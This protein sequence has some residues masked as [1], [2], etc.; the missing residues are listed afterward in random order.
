MTGGAEEPR[1]ALAALARRFMF[2]LAL[3]GVVLLVYLAIRFRAAHDQHALAW[4]G[5]AVIVIAFGIQSGRARPTLRIGIAL[6]CVGTVVATLGLEWT[7][8]AARRAGFLRNQRALE[9]LTGVPYDSRSIPQV[10]SDLWKTDSSVVPSIVP[11]IIAE[12]SQPATDPRSRFVADI[13]PLAGVSD[14]RTVQLCNEHGA[15]PLYHSDQHGFLNPPAAWAPAPG[16][17]VVIGDSF[18]HGYCV[19]ADSAF[20]NVLRQRWPATLNLGMG[21]NGPLAELATLTEYGIP[22]DPGVVLWVYFENDLPDL[23]RERQDPWL[24]RYLAPGFTQHLWQRQASVDSVLVPWIRRVYTGGMA[25]RFFAVYGL[26]EVLT[27]TAIRGLVKRAMAGKPPSSRDQLRLF[28]QV[29]AAARERVAARGARLVMV[30]LP[31]WERTFAPAALV[32]DESRG[33]VIG[34]ATALGVPVIDLTPVFA[35]QPDRAAL[36]GRRDIT[37][38][39][40]SAAGYQVVAHTIERALDSLGLSATLAGAA[41]ARP[42]V[43]SG[44]GHR[45]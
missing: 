9:K 35:A 39:H 5:I 6:F 22:A 16:R 13:F 31:E 12:Y 2:G 18:T 20:P 40:Y 37:S 36:F 19:P 27:L 33:G 1:G 43:G 10:V 41:V 11:S 30:F 7:I 4:Y 17:L 8:S 24:M 34:A 45:K 14:R 3:A 29:L 25:P 32:D 44:D 28:G 26:R 23:R 21:G 15:Y 38:A 42:Q